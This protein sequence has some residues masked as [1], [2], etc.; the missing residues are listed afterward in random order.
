MIFELIDQKKYLTIELLERW[1]DHKA[2]KELKQHFVECKKRYI[3][4]VL[5]DL[6][7]CE[8]VSSEGIGLLISMWHFF[9]NEGTILFVITDKEILEMLKDCGLYVE[10]RKCIFEDLQ[11]AQEQI[12]QKTPSG[13]Y[14]TGTKRKVCPV[15]NSTNIGIYDKGFK[16]LVRFLKRKKG[17]YVCKDCYLVWRKK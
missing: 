6:S 15:C 14:E 11:I 12:L 4:R 13:Y 8:M 16:R 9:R 1:L 10:M 7:H 2:T 5:L 17:R 3:N